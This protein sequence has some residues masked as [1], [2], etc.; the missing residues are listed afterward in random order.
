M[1][2][3]VYILLFENE[4]CH[5]SVGALGTLW[6]KGGWHGY[7]GSALGPGGFARVQRHIDLHRQGNRSPMWHIDRI[8]LSPH[9]HLRYAI[10]GSTGE[11]K[12]CSL[13]RLLCSGDGSGF[14]A[15]DCRCATHLFYRSQNPL[16]EIQSA[17]A[18]LDLIPVI[19]SINTNR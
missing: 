19:K 11:R 8:L 18:T 17:F 12:E 13:A 2:E 5:L 7:V 15:S 16:G 9:F 1:T 10:C 14:G 6:L 4:P 3:G